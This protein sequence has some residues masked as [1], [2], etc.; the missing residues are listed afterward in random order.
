MGF[1]VIDLSTDVLVGSGAAGAMAAI[2]ATI[3]V[4]VCWLLL[5]DFTLREILQLPSVDTE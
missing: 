5:R 4:P 3:R 2:K 1:E